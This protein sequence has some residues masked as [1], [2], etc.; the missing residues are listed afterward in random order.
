VTTSTNLT[1]WLP[2]AG[3]ENLRGDGVTTSEVLSVSTE[4]HRFWRVMADE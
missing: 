3:L 4:R 2:V 1:D